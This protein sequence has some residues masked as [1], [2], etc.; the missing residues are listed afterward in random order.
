MRPFH[1]YDHLSINLLWLTT[2][3]RNNAVGGLFMPF[4]VDMFVSPDIK[5]TA[6]GSLRTAG[7]LI[8][9]IAQPAFGLLSDHN[10]SRFGRRRPYI[11]IGV[12]LDI[13][14]LSI[15]AMVTSYPALVISMMLLQLTSNISHGPLQ[16]II[17]DLVPEEQRGVSSG[18]KAVFELIPLIVVG[19]F[20]AGL[21]SQ[22]YF[23]WAML[24]TAISM[25]VIMLI[26]VV[27]VKEQP[28][29]QKPDTPFWPP[30]VR[31]LVMIFGSL[32]G[33]IVGLL[34]GGIVGGLA[35]IAAWLVQGEEWA[36][37]IGVSLGGLAA[38]ICAITAGV[39]G[40]VRL[41]AGKQVNGQP[42]S[43]APFTW[44][45]INRLFFLA[46]ITSLQGFAPFFFMYAFHLDREAAVGMTGGLM[47]MVGIFTLLTALP[48]G[49]ISDRI[50]RKRVIGISTIMAGLA[51]IVL[52]STVWYPSI[53][54]VYVLGSLLGLATG[55]F[56]SSNWAMGASIV[57]PD[58]A[59][60]FLGIANLAGA[61][62]GIVGAGMGGPIAD[63]LN[64]ISSG[65]GYF[66]LFASYAVLFF[67]SCASLTQIVEQKPGLKTTS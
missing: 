13:V 11:L 66:V 62:A 61:G 58:E 8:A 36:R 15:I 1:W 3:I 46:A 57:P 52:L 9:M 39:W 47:T 5:N 26:F 12:L 7:L 64:N 54:V 6:L 10:K 24:V 63:Y 30:M 48:G 17:P 56:M 55:L 50:G 22:G 42:V 53:T 34:V 38:M 59:G 31:V 27:L 20:I 65:L 18:I 2:N 25:L 67:L 43:R 60:R 41:A 33:V 40:G 45:V 21:V 37:I 51:T 23:D 35:G 29:D 19:Y 14:V 4:L 44:W 16:A 32:A 28:L 49:W